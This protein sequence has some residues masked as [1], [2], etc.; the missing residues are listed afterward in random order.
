MQDIQIGIDPLIQRIIGFYYTFHI[1][2][3]VNESRLWKFIRVLIFL[4]CTI[5]YPV[6]LAAGG[7]QVSTDL[8]DSI[9]LLTLAIVVAVLEFKGFYIFFRQDDILNLVNGT[10]IQSVPNNEH[11]LH[12]VNKKLDILSKCCVIFIVLSVALTLFIIILS[13]P[14]ISHKMPFNIWFPLDYNGNNTAHWIAHCF[15][16]INEFFVLIVSPLSTMT[17]Y[18]MLNCSI[19]YDILGY[20][21]QNLGL[22]T[23]SKQLNSNAK[24]LDMFEFELI[25]CIQMHIQLEKYRIT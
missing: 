21:F 16:L 11:L 22:T 25:E 1:W 14:L 20:R 17:W 12:R 8:G 4:F 18:I 23:G 13:S 10:C 7:G 5:S 2:Q 9:F 19:K 6:A 15:V 3:S 24:N